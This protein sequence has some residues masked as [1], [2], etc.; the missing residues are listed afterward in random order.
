MLCKYMSDKLVLSDDL[1][2]G[3]ERMLVVVVTK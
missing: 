2:K 1:G 3:N